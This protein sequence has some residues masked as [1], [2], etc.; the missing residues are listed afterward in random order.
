LGG[1]SAFSQE[2]LTR[3]IAQAEAEVRQ[4]KDEYAALLQN[5]YDRTTVQQ[6]R[7]YYDE[8]LGWAN[9]FDLATIQRKRAILVQL[10]E[11]VEVGK[12]Y[13]IAI[14]VNGQYKQFLGDVAAERNKD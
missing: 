7:S 14:Y 12:G 2:V 8:F 3:L 9:E 10:L 4:A 11:K 13:R 1:E 5:N 6:N